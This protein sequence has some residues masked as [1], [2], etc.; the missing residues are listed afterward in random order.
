MA[1]SKLTPEQVAATAK[2]VIRGDYGV[3]AERKALLGANYATVQAE[4]NRLLKPTAAPA[5]APAPAPT[6]VVSTTPT[7]YTRTPEQAAQDFFAPSDYV[8]APS[9]PTYQPDT[10]GLEMAREQARQSAYGVI[11]ELL[12]AY[13][14]GALTDFVNQ[15]VF[16][17]NVMDANV[18]MGRIRQTSE[19]KQRFA[20]NEQRRTKGLNALSES[21]YTS[22]ERVYMQYL[23]ASGLPKE[24]YDQ[25]TD[26]QALLANDVSVAELAS[27]I[28]QGYE[29]VKNS[30]PQVVNE[31]RRLYGVT[32]SQLAAYFL[33]PERATP[34]L[35][36]QAQSAQIAAQSTIQAGIELQQGTAE[37]LA[38]AGVTAEQ[39]QQGFQAIRQAQ[40]LFAATPTEQAITTEEQIAG[41][42]GTSGEAQQR[43]RTRQRARQAQFEVGGRF[44]GQG[45]TLTGLQ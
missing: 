7:T 41:V 12:N 22:M 14:L 33:D 32:D 21:E 16:N 35:L 18:L 1:A 11:S 19:Y 27:R 36:R 39:A 9:A 31:M 3:G 10:S 20:A 6:G 40:D 13:G 34:I 29:A 42:F 23:R 44:A 43:I 38:A 15:L 26:V 45:S 5:P 37:Q 24:M 4:V 17:E 30:D 8:P 25:N 2:A 28:N